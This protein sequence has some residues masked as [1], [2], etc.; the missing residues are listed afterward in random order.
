MM[1]SMVWMESL[2]WTVASTRWPVSAMVR[3]KEMLSRSRIS[4]TIT[5]SGSSRTTACRAVSKDSV[6]VPT[7]RWL[8]TA[9]L[10]VCTC[11]I[12]S[13]MVTMWHGRLRLM[14]SIIEARVVDFPDPVGPVTRTGPLAEV[15]DPGHHHRDRPTP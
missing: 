2:V 1:R 7:W 10:L 3:A 8:T 12:G 5:T 9:C 6:S 4:P 15:Q 13:S 14:A 11:S